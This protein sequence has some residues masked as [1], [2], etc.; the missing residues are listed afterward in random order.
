MEDQLG[1]GDGMPPLGA[2]NFRFEGEIPRCS[3]G[4]P[5]YCTAR[6]LCNRDLNPP[7]LFKCT[8]CHTITKDDDPYAFKLLNQ[9]SSLARSPWTTRLECDDQVAG[10]QEAELL[11]DNLFCLS[12][13]KVVVCEE[14]RQKK[15]V[16]V[17]KYI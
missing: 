3:D 10:A 4:F 6:L 16:L 15:R 8:A 7:E 17:K 1:D 2:R 9:G 11:V 12:K 5:V 13:V 14:V